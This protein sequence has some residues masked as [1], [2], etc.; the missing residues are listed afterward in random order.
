MRQIKAELL[1]LTLGWHGGW[2]RGGSPSLVPSPPPQGYGFWR[3]LGT[4][5]K[6]LDWENFRVPQNSVNGGSWESPGPT[7]GLCHFKLQVY[8]E[9]TGQMRK[10]YMCSLVKVNTPSYDKTQWTRSHISLP[11]DW[12]G[13]NNLCDLVVTLAWPPFHTPLKL[14]APELTCQYLW[15]RSWSESYTQN[16]YSVWRQHPW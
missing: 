9:W 1:W 4:Q 7:S 15:L 11:Q 12:W 10:K 5:L 16:K 3:I 6:T 8:Q 14:K 13:L 2:D